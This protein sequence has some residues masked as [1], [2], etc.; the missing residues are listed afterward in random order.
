MV[1]AYP[2]H[3]IP[4]DHDF[5]LVSVD[6]QAGCVPAVRGVAVAVAAQ[7]HASGINDA[8]YVRLVGFG[9]S[10]NDHGFFAIGQLD[11]GAGRVKTHRCG[12]G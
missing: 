1:G 8:C 2:G 6:G 12:H 11:V 3:F 7:W 4:A 10:G 5:D 9:A